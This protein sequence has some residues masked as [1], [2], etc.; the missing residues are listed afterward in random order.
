MSNKCGRYMVV[1]AM[2][3]CIL[4]LQFS[5]NNIVKAAGSEDV[6]E[7]QITVNCTGIKTTESNGNVSSRENALTRISDLFIRGDNLWTTDSVSTNNF[8]GAKPGETLTGE[9]GFI[10]VDSNGNKITSMDVTVQAFTNVDKEGVAN[11]IYSAVPNVTEN[12]KKLVEQM[13][14]LSD[15]VIGAVDG[16]YDDKQYTCTITFNADGTFSY[17]L[18]E[19]LPDNAILAITQIQDPVTKEMVDLI[20]LNRLFIATGNGGDTSTDDGKDNDDNNNDDNN[21]GD[22]N[23]DNNG[24]DPETPNSYDDGHRYYSIEQEI[25]RY[26]DLKPESS[27]SISSNSYNVS[28][29]IPTSENL[30]YSLTTD[31]ALYDIVTRKTTLKTGVKNITLRLSATY[32]QEYKNTYYNE[33]GDLIEEVTKKDET[34]Y[35]TVTTDYDYESILTLYDVPMSSIYPVLNGSVFADNNGN[36]LSSGTLS[37]QGSL[38]PGGQVLTFSIGVPDVKDTVTINLGHF[39]SKSKARTALNANNASNVKS[40][41]NGKVIAARNYLGNVNYAYYGLNV[42]ST[43]HNYTTPVVAKTSNSSTNL[44]PSTY[45]NGLYK[46]SGSVVY[47]GNKTFNVTPNNAVVHTPVVNNSYISSTSEFIN[48]KINIDS[49]RTYLML[50]EEFTI[51]IPNN[52]THNDIKG[53]R[54]RNYNSGQ[55]VTKY[56]TTWAKIKDVRLPFDAYLHYTKNGV[57]Y[58]YFVKANTW[59]S[60]S[61]AIDLGIS[62]AVNQYTFTIPVWVTEQTY[63]IETRTIAENA[64]TAQMIALRENGKN[65]SVTNYVAYKTI[66]VEVIGKIYDLR[67]S[68]SNDPGWAS[69]YSWKN[70]TN[71]IAADEF[72]FGSQGQNKIQQYKYAPKLGYSFVFEFKTKGTKSNNIDVSIQPEGF[73]F[74][75][76]DGKTTQ[77]VDL[78]YNT[79]T[80][81]NIKISTADNN[82]SLSVRLRDSY[83]KVA[84]QELSDSARIY[85]NKYNYSLSVNIGT[86]AKMNL[87]HSLRLC[88]NNFTEYI[89][90][91][92][93]KGATEKSISSNAGTKDTVIASVGHWYAGYRLPAS[94]KAI[95]AG[96]DINAAV[97]NNS[98]LTDGYIV[99]KFDIKTKYQNNSGNYDYLQYVGPEA[100]NEAGDNTGKLIVDWTKEGNQTVILPNGNTAEVPVGSVAIFEASLRSSNDAEVGGTH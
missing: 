96:S 25:I 91:L 30:N 36:I 6:P 59:L 54:N 42:T 57:S 7:I 10:P 51:T 37:L 27:A 55:G 14:L 39:G 80:K 43:S 11:G 50:D 62:L 89:N 71:Y 72:P 82:T 35:R 22:N 24:N 73:Y 93:G 79:T 29:G 78:Y 15:D 64:M 19:E 99:V 60:E 92:Y 85:K 58:K 26:T 5:N 31:N 83:L 2:L 41:V 100:L 70:K 40:K 90:A 81:K 12:T 3:I 75:S 17:H 4:T 69:I 86:F 48:Q 95:P 33:S 44:I 28:Q 76:K 46:G 16:N 21:N 8:N 52:G 45:P 77:E 49:S 32:T 18:S 88:Y 34:I 56:Q 87:P 84:V 47:A 63:D 67:I 20:E 74:V 65:S 97:K 23:N 98:F 68:A 66:P 53:Y 61:G 94:T 13:I 38:T 9:A 1:I